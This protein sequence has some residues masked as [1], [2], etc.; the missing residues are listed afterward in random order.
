MTTNFFITM[1]LYFFL[2]VQ[3]YLALVPGFMR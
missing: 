3:D 1:F 2:I